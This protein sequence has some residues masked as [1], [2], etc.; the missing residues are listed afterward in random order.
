MQ[1]ISLAQRARAAGHP[2]ALLLE[3]QALLRKAETDKSAVGYADARKVLADAVAAG[4]GEARYFLYIAYWNPVD[5]DAAQA[6]TVLRAG[7]AANDANC[8][9]TLATW[10]EKGNPPVEQNLSSAREH[11]AQAARAGHPRARQWCIDYANQLPPTAPDAD[12]AWVEKNADV[13]RP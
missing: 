13:C 8:L 6:A 2:K 5:N 3:G 4:L 10:E 9:Y 1:A 7:A 11:Y 12:R